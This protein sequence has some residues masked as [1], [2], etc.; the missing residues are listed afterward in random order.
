VKRPSAAISIASLILGFW[1]LVYVVPQVVAPVELFANHAPLLA[2]G[3][4]FDEGPTHWMGTNLLGH[5][6]YAYV[7]WTGRQTLKMAA[8][9]VA[10]TY[11]F[12]A[13]VIAPLAVGVVYG[14]PFLR[15]ACELGIY[16]CRAIPVFVA[17]IVLTG[18]I[19]YAYATAIAITLGSAAGF[20]NLMKDYSDK[21]FNVFRGPN[22]AKALGKLVLP[23]FLQKCRLTLVL[24][25]SLE[26]LMYFSDWGLGYRIAESRSLIVS[27][28]L[29][30]LPY[31]LGV[32]SMLLG[33]ELFS[34]V[35]RRS[36][37]NALTNEERSIAI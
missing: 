13:L 26:F 32:F 8:L 14:N 34:I 15:P 24:L 6:I 22:S 12:L 7:V 33:I 25:L 27:H 3:Q 29:L 18:W 17:F 23:D 19:S 31:L 2:A 16:V 37:G 30:M 1:T 4:S 5:D 35:A 28:P 9:V 21:G 36:L 10:L 11:L 20:L